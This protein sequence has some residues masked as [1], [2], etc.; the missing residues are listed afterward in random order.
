MFPC[1]TLC[2]FGS[3]K[4]LFI[5][6]KLLQHYSKTGNWHNIKRSTTN[7]RYTFHYFMLIC[8]MLTLSPHPPA[9]QAGYSVKVFTYS[10]LHSVNYYVHIKNCHTRYNYWWCYHQKDFQKDESAGFS[11]KL[12]F[13]LTGPWD[14]L[15][16]MKLWITPL[17]LTTLS[18][19]QLKTLLVWYRD[20]NAHLGQSS[21]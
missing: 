7:L 17:T 1:Y 16:C 6:Q 19:S 9:L 2:K 15:P 8:N 4:H 18:A 21:M 5:F 11:S 14:F 20:C 10:D 13:L 3:F 12:Q